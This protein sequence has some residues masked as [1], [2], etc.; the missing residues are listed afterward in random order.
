MVEI[1]TAANQTPHH[2]W[3]KFVRTSRAK[4]KIKHWIKAE[5]QS[6]SVEI[7]KRLLEAEFRRHGLAPAQMMRSDQLLPWPSRSVM[8][9][10]MNW[11]QRLDSAT[12][13]R[14]R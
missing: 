3:L 6:R 5:E 4:T 1:L 11:P 7:G 9:R 14:L 2:D 12:S 13:R 10:R 8:T